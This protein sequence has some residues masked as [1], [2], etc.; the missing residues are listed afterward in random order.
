MKAVIMA[1]GEGTR[2]RPLTCGMPKPMIPVAN[3]PVM[4][5]II[6]LLKKYNI[7]DIAV[8]L[9]Y[10]PEIIKEY[11]QDGRQFG[12]NLNY[13]IEE[14]PL[15]TAGSVKNAEELLTDTFIVISGDALTDIDL[16]KA[17]D[18]HNKK[19]SMA[20]L[21]LKK[22]DVPLEYGVVVTDSDG[23]IL[24]FLEKPGWG[25]V[26]SNTVNT[27]IYILSPEIFKLYT[28][29]EVFDFSNDLFPMILQNKLP[30]YGVVSN[31]YWC[32]IGDLMAY[33]SSHNDVMDEKIKLNIKGTRQTQ[34]Q[35]KNIW[36][37]ENVMI[38]KDV[39]MEGPAIIGDNCSIGD[40]CIIGP[41]TVIGDGNRI[42]ERCGLKRSIIWRSNVIQKNVQLRGS[43]ICDR[44]IIKDNVSTFE[45]SVIG[46]GTVIDSNATVRQ[47]IKIW[48]NKEIESRSE[49]S[50]NLVW[51]SRYIQ[52]IFGQKGLAGEINVDITPEF[53]TK[54]GA[55]WGSIIKNAKKIGISC[56]GTNTA[57]MIK[58]AFTAGVLSSGLKVWDIGETLIPVTRNAIR[59]Y[60]LDGGLH[61][62]TF[63]DDRNKLFIEFT[64]RHG[65]NIDRQ[66]ERKI[67]NAFIREDF[68]RSE[69]CNIRGITQ[70]KDYDK[71]YTR[72]I[73]NQLRASLFHSKV[74][75]ACE[76][77]EFRS[78][79]DNIMQDM[80]CKYNFYDSNLNDDTNI[81]RVMIQDS[82]DIGFKVDD[83]CEEIMLFD[84][85]G[86]KVEKN[87]YSV[88]SAY[89][90][91]KNVDHGNLSLNNRIVSPVY[92][93]GEI[94]N[95]AINNALSIKKT[96]TSVSEIMKAIIE[97]DEKRID[98][99]E[100]FIMRFDA[101][102]AIVKILDFM[103]VNDLKISKI[104]SELP[105]SFMKEREVACGWNMKG[106]VIKE[107][108]HDNRGNPLETIEGVKVKFPKGWVLV[109]PDAERPVCRIIA[110]GFNEETAAELTDFYT[111]KITQIT[112]NKN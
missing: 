12:V 106:K 74:L 93:S 16:A 29:G 76:N 88:L 39:L 28:K 65:C 87:Q 6:E 35:A 42:S 78:L 25:E 38:G 67:E 18:F 95:M 36:I 100:Q 72:N 37:G 62:G 21:I 80:G 7:D 54:L 70:I 101:P 43:I 85:T 109:L 111:K 108:M 4:E 10:M 45:E 50:S 20:T 107:I 79:I 9:Y 103:A 84:D 19:G 63:S 77:N 57:S 47:G 24:R 5:H 32:D 13:F 98:F 82:Y 48:P 15:G 58:M 99:D 56:D 23:K 33:M 89:I 22:V 81:S 96:K 94:E 66:M 60:G 73:L 31:E 30:M 41:Y 3:R 83:E 46:S 105:Q 104:I 11:F 92:E 34:G 27:G 2:L 14:K 75:I 53:A 55:A 1:G 97:E 44:T 112:N 102:G 110:E 64:D 71:V 40:G 69:A 90:S 59:F 68:V 17:V 91:M 52:N 8:T 26:F 86:K 49:V 51:G 61:I